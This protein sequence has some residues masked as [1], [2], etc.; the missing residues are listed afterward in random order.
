MHQ[1]YYTNDQPV[2]VAMA[3]VQLYNNSFES[4]VEW[5]ANTKVSLKRF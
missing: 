1:Y 5:L 3:Q 4:L 2:P